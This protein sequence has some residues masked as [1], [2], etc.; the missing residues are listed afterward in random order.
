MLGEPSPKVETVAEKK[1]KQSIFSVRKMHLNV[2]NELNRLFGP[3][4]AD[5]N[6][7]KP[8][9]QSKDIVRNPITPLK[10]YP[11]KNMGLS[12]AV[13]TTR[14]DITYFVYNHNTEYQRRHRELIAHIEQGN[15]PQGVPI[16]Q[17]FANMHVE[18]ML[19]LFRLYCRAEEYSNANSLLENLIGYLQFTAHPLFN[20]TNVSTRLE[21]TYVENRAFHI[22]ILLY[23]Y[24]LSNK[25]CHRTALELAKMLMNLDPSDPLGVIFIIDTFAIRAREYAWLIEAIDYW[26]V[27]RDAKYLFNMKYSYA[28]AHFH[29]LNN[30]KEDLKLADKLLKDAL[31]LFPMGLLAI[32]STTTLPLTSRT[33][34]ISSHRLFTTYARTIFPLRDVIKLYAAMIGSRWVEPPVLEWLLRNADELIDVFDNDPAVQV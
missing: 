13:V 5:G 2:S 12:M 29:V 3:D 20:I 10:T 7:K 6:R 4:D 34:K 15:D 26:E 22:A 27:N 17:S 21:Y 16:L 9:Q 33:E 30:K 11:F 8:K 24:L 19:E 18:G 14:D 1:P 28:L 32:L 31:M 23:S 25:A